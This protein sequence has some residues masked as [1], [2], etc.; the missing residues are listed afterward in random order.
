MCIWYN[1]GIDLGGT[2]VKKALVIMLVFAVI[3]APAV[4]FS[5]DIES[6]EN[7]YIEADTILASYIENYSA[8][9]NDRDD[10][11]E[12]YTNFR[13]T[14][15]SPFNTAQSKSTK[16][17]GIRQIDYNILNSFN[18]IQSRKA[19]LVIDFRSSY[20]NLYSALSS[21]AIYKTEASAIKNEYNQM[22]KKK[23]SGFISENELLKFEYQA[24]ALQNT[25]NSMDRLYESA[26][27]NFNFKI[28]MPLDYDDYTF[29][30][31]E[32]IR[33]I[34]SLD[35]YISN[36]LENSSSV[37]QLKQT[38]E[39]YYVEQKNYDVYSFSTNLK[40]IVDALRTIEINIRLSELKLEN[41]K[42]TLIN[43]IKTKYSSLSIA[44]EQINLSKMNIDV[45]QHEYYINST[46]YNRGFIDKAE[47][48]QSSDSLEKARQEYIML[49]YKTNTQ[50]KSLE[51]DCAYYPEESS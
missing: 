18:D 23:L 29:D 3:L 32:P 43:N 12:K 24:L 42:S 45:L 41:T 31:K 37:I 46:L 30:F 6:S 35:F 15:G 39:K 11:I 19:Q 4:V 25:S 40:Y 22:V 50:I 36:A 2:C 27:R 9:I 10:E 21:S 48:A 20:S 13:I 5:Y 26:L 51:N 1:F 8:L 38:L 7:L 33:E 44:L 14:Y 47:L 34:M 17:N 49:I 28:G 16:E